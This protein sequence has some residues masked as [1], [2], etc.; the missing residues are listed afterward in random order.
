MMQER[1]T[2]KSARNVVGADE[3]RKRKMLK[4]V[5]SAVLL[6]SFMTQNFLYYRWNARLQLL[7]RGNVGQSLID[8][9]VL[10]NEVLYFTARPAPGATVDD[11]QKFYIHEAARNLAMSSTFPVLSRE[12]L[13]TQERV[14]LSNSLLS[15]ARGVSDFPSFVALIKRVNESYGQY[16]QEMS[17]EV[18]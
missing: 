17:D 7:D 5:G 3:Q 12:G 8:K 14:D 18:V 10:L 2:M 11:L 6:L 13:K 9:S 4:L 15:E 1:K 16:S